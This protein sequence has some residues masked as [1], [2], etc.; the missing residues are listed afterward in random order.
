[1]TLHYPTPHCLD[2]NVRVRSID[3]L[4]DSVWRETIALARSGSMREAIYYVSIA[5]FT[6]HYVTAEL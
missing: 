6:A 3:H 5:S 2:N 1:M 4:V